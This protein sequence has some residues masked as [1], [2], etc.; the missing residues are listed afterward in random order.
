MTRPD[1]VHVLRR[2]DANP[3]LTAADVPYPA[4]TVFNPGAA[5]VGDET[6]L[7]SADRGP[8]GH[9]PASRRPQHGRG[10]RLA[11][12]P[13]AALR[14]D[15]DHY[16]EEM[17]G[18]EDPRLT[19]LPEREEWAIA[20]TAYSRRG[21][22]VSLAMTRDF[23]S[24]PPT[25]AGHAAGGQ[26]RGPLPAPLR[27]PLGHDPP[28]L[29]APGRRPHVDLVLARPPPL[30]RPHAAPRG[31][32]RRL[33]GCRQDRPRAA[34]PRDAR[35]VAPHVPR[36]PRHR[37][38]ADLPGGTGPAGPR[39]PAPSSSAGRTSGSSG[40]RHRTRSPGTSAASSSPAG[41]SWI[42]PGRWSASTTAPATRSWGWPRCA[43]TTSWPACARPESRPSGTS[44]IVDGR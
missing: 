6:I 4:N 18:C 14:S 37:R 21:P 24:R 28:P 29:A 5:R 38:R 3:I 10:H 42:R 27:R 16:P 36:R 35:G 7:L 31:A 40:R 39:E 23:H 25:R 15:P 22:L 8:P 9:L 13:G 12:R 30:G 26:G 19:F 17:W 33:V 34:A 1:D 43:S 32:R 20:Y 44:A 11:V 2:S 41:G